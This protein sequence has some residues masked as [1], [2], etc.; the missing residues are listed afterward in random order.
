[1]TQLGWESGL[2]V[3]RT[4]LEAGV[5]GNC[6][7]KL[8]VHGRQRLCCWV[9]ESE[10]RGVEHSFSGRWQSFHR[11]WEHRRD[12]SAPFTFSTQSESL[13]VAQ[14]CPALYDPM[15]CSL[16][17]S[18]LSMGILQARILEW[19]AIPFSRGFSRPTDQTQISCIAG[20]FFTIWAMREACHP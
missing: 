12:S 5:L 14:S 4:V 19:V 18:S 16:P 8:G 10:Q 9:S 20:R 6:A 7:W 11:R 17:G 15:D 2:L 1:M 13:L 3:K